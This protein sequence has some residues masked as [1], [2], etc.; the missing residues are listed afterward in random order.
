VCKS[1]PVG[2]YTQ[3]ISAAALIPARCA[4][5]L[6]DFLRIESFLLPH[7]PLSLTLLFESK[8]VQARGSFSEE[9]RKRDR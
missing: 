4:D 2:I 9:K 8:K 7:T 5:L 1:Q 3:T 6:T